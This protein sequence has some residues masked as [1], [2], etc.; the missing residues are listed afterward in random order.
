MR[1][2]CNKRLRN[3]M[4]QAAHVAVKYVERWKRI[5]SNLRARGCSHARALRSVADRM[6]KVLI[7]M[8]RDGACFDL[9]RVERRC[10][11]ARGVQHK[12]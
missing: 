1:R 4:H 7:A 11:A 6:L 3:A 8:L 2:A 10:T 12:P 9:D 5:Y